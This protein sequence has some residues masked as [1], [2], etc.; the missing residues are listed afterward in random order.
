[1]IEFLKSK[2]RLIRKRDYVPEKIY[3]KRWGIL[4]VLCF[5][6]LVVMIGNTSLNVAL[7]ILSRELHASS[8][9]LQWM[10]DAYSLI[11]AGLLFTA[12]AFGDRFGRKGILQGG[13]LLF[14]VASAY[15]AFVADSA[16]A[17]IAARAVM[18]LAGAMIMPA[19]LSI[20]TNVFPPKERAKA[21]G[22]WAGTTGI[23]VAIGPILTGFL[24]E[25]FSWH[26]VF[27]I[28]IPIIAVTI[29][30]AAWLVP[31]T[32][33]PS[34]S[35]LD[36]LGGLLSTSG[37][38]AL[39][40]AIIEAPSHGW[41]SASTLGI[42]AAGLAVLG[43]FIWWELRVKHPMLD[44]RLFKRPAFGISS[45]SLTL[46][47]FALQGMFF[48]FSL[49]L[50]LIHGYSPLSSSIRLLPVAA[51]LTVAAPLS[52]P[53]AKR[54]GKRRVVAGGMLLVSLGTLI[55]STVGITSPYSQLVGG[56]VVLALGMGLAMSPTTDLLMSAVPKSRAGMGSA[57]N[58]TTRELGGA[59]GIAV[60]GSIL[61]SQY[62]SKIAP[63][64]VGL[65]GAAKEAAASSLAGAMA[66]GQQIGGTTGNAFIAAAQ[67]AWMSGFKRSLMI[68]AAIIA[69]AAV[70]AFLGLPDKASDE[71]PEEGNFE[72]EE[73]EEATV[74]A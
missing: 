48:S 66:V 28:N 71:I 10:V 20:I 40:Y 5:A 35:S 65:T 2:V 12:G 55:V 17:I 14:G 67:D 11:F 54:L 45:L 37:L 39:V 62:A 58:D 6:L 16:G 52:T 33:D 53:L 41:L 69:V 74:T 15:S 23:G 7:P 9:Q 38:I 73:A 30:A 25:H 63:A 60:L 72:I 61:A 1:M 24:L 57:M 49:F 8:S 50:Q 13:L 44:I 70:I 19:T 31:R 43:L 32:A 21:V 42:G 36:P 3:Q 18:G 64:L 26:S 29:L 4:A 47:F 59:L 46:V 34:H 68:G 56:M 22:I 51:T 27:T